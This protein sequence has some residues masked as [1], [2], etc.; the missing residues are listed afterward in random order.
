[1]LTRTICAEITRT[2]ANH[3]CTELIVMWTSLAVVGIHVHA[4]SCL[5]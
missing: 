5:L 3:T 4:N 2:N 1:M